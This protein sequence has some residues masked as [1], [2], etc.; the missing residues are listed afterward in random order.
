MEEF[1]SPL[2]KHPILID[3]THDDIESPA[4]EEQVHS[5]KLRDRVFPEPNTPEAFACS[6]TDA[7]VSRSAASSRQIVTPPVAGTRTVSNSQ[8]PNVIDLVMEDSDSISYS[9]VLQID[10]KG[11]KVSWSS[12]AE[13]QTDNVRSQDHRDRLSRTCPPRREYRRSKQW[14][15]ANFN[16]GQTLGT[17]RQRE[18]TD[19]ELHDFLGFRNSLGRVYYKSFSLKNDLCQG[20]FRVGCS[21]LLATEEYEEP[22]CHRIISIFQATRS[23]VGQWYGTQEI[24]KRSHCYFEFESASAE[25]NSVYEIPQWILH[26]YLKMV[27]CVAIDDLERG[28]ETSAM[29][30]LLR[31]ASRNWHPKLKAEECT[32]VCQGSPKSRQLS[33]TERWN[34][35][36]SDDSDEFEDASSELAKAAATKK[37]KSEGRADSC[38]R[39]PVQKHKIA[40]GRKKASSVRSSRP[41]QSSGARKRP[42]C[43]MQKQR[44]HPSTIQTSDTEKMFI[45]NSTGHA[46]L[47]NLLVQKIRAGATMKRDSLLSYFLNH[48]WLL[49]ETPLHNFQGLFD[50]R[51]SKNGETFVLTSVKAQADTSVGSLNKMGSLKCAHLIYTK[52]SGPGVAPISVQNLLLQFGDFSILPARKVVARLELLQSPS[53]TFTVG[54]KKHYGMFCLQASDFVVMAEEG[55]DGCGFI[56]EELLASLF[57]NSK[58]AKQLLGPQVRV[59]APRLGIFKGMLIRKRIPVGE[60]PIQLTPSM[61]KVGPSRYSENDIRAFLLVTNQG[62]HPSVN[63]DAL[64]KLLN[65][66]LDNPPPSWKQ[67]GFAER[68]QMLPLL[69]RTL[70]VPAIVM[71]R[72][73]REY[74]SQTRCRIHHTFMPGYADPTGA[75]PHGHVFVTGSK[76]FQENLLFVTRSPCI[77]PSDGRL[78]PNLV[79]KPNAMV[80]DDWNWLNS[81]PFGALIFADATPGMKPLPAHIANGDLD[82]DLYFVCW[83]SEILRN[84]RADPI[85]EEPLTLT[86]GEVASTPQAKMPPENPNWFE[87]ALEIMCDPAE[88]AEISAFYGKLFNLALKAA[89]NN[90]NNLLLRDPDAMDYATAYNQALDYHKHGRLVQ[91]PRRLHSSIPTRFHQYL[92]KT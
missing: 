89:L 39:T 86:D 76:P 70:G 35:D 90:P 59:V 67:N 65:P 31:S 74:Y 54:Q 82:G 50:C 22:T 58:A 73:Q 15:K 24:Q 1:S 91:L 88:L 63:N 92:A 71:E 62:K 11:G 80:I 48:R 69:L 25:Q 72:Y 30:L 45:E 27:N 9:E 5:T 10:R 49:V 52:I 75:I 23:Y 13:E 3:L 20:T 32:F 55:N 16:L 44:C 40:R 33:T 84:V 6:T 64:G 21:V 41:R 61:R 7:A 38:Q 46:V 2:T 26:P 53:C 19:L 12:A 83:D 47:G 85:V 66:L 29:R 51:F 18:G 77:F 68:S 57:G 79:T 36:S 8:D 56:S 78:L 42:A 81:L 43:P 14:T 28:N 87:E 17:P 60:P 4:A 37:R 34:H